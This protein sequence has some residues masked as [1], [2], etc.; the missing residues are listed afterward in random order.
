MRRPA[1]AALAEINVTPLIDVMLVLLIVFMLVAPL[2]TRS[3]D[4][5]LPEKARGGDVVARP[6]ALVVGVDPTGLTLNGTPVASIAEL[7]V[8][9]RDV[10]ASRADRTVFVNA[11]GGVSFGDVVDVLDVVRGAGAD[12][13]GVTTSRH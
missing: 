8:R 3:L 5:G 10:L 6:P 9:L 2:A 1:I 7:R 13:L 11:A 12:R 4:V